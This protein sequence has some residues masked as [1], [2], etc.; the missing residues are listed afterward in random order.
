MILDIN[1][2][3]YTEEETDCMLGTAM[4][5]LLVRATVQKD[6]TVY[7]MKLYFGSTVYETRVPYHEFNQETKENVWTDLL[8]KAFS[9]HDIGK[10]NKGAIVSLMRES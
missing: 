4:L 8:S 6:D 5:A 9:A 3:A 10:L 7:K 1:G 2:Q